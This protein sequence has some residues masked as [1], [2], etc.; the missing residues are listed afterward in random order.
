MPARTVYAYLSS[1]CDLVSDR[2][3]IILQALCMQ[4]KRKSE[5]AKKPRK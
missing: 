5:R 1:Q 3:S 2:V 4:I